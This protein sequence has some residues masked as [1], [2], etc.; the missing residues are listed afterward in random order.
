M[1]EKIKKIG[2]NPYYSPLL[3]RKIKYKKN[4]NN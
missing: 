2:A 1:G 4:N 3:N